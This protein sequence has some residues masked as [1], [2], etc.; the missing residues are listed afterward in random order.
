MQGQLPR[1]PDWLKVRLPHGDIYEQMREHLAGLNTVCASAR[2]P[3]LGECWGKG[4]CT[5]MVLGNTC[6][7][8]CRFCGVKHARRG[9]PV[10]PSEPERLAK[11]A[12]EI[13]LGYVVITSVDRDDLPDGGAGHYA[14]CIRAVKSELPSCKVEAIVPD[15]SGQKAA[16]QLILL[17]RPDVLAHNVEVV[18]R[19]TPSIRDHRASYQQSLDVLNSI[20]RLAP[21]IITKSSIMLGLGETPGEIEA[22]IRDIRSANVDVLTIGQYLR[23]DEN[24]IEVVRYV[25][26]EEFDALADYARS[27]GFSYVASG[28]F[29]RSSYKAADYFDFIAAGR[30]ESSGR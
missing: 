9:E 15:F 26:P 20:K 4:C 3:N 5:F 12:R 23:P 13:G 11:A 18:E 19:L 7:R 24:S 29:V 27:T 8:A 16:L 6:T 28:P 10:D 25:P 21:G 14:A 30:A 2:C 22:T 1:K 17:S